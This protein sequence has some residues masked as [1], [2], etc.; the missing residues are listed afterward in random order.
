MGNYDDLNDDNKAIYDAIMKKSFTN[1]FK[2]MTKEHEEYLKG[3]YKEAYETIKVKD[4]KEYTK[5]DVQV[6]ALLT[7][8]SKKRVQAQEGSKKTNEEMK[9]MMDDKVKEKKVTSS[10]R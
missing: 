4:P 7:K 2:S 9:I 1:V 10:S 6:V 3:I 8:L 5:E